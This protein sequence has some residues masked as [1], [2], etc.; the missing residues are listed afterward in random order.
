MLP[1]IDYLAHNITLYS[2]TTLPR[3]TCLHQGRPQPYHNRVSAPRPPV[4]GW[5]RNTASRLLAHRRTLSDSDK[6]DRGRGNEYP[7]PRAHSS[8]S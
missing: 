4:S 2:K 7:P 5:P 6:D 1:A 8:V 3:R